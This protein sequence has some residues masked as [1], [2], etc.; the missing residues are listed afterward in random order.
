M[1]H[2]LHRSGNPCSLGQDFV[3]FAIA[4]QGFNAEGSEPKFK[5]FA[6]IAL[7]YNPVNFGDMKQG[8][9]YLVNRDEILEGFKS[10]SIMH[11]VF[12]NKDTMIECLK[13]IS[14]ADIGL[15]IVV[16]GLIHDVTEA[17]CQAGIKPH[18]VEHSLGVHGTTEKL[19]SQAVLDIS[20]MCGHGM[21]AFS[22]IEHL[23][24]EVKSGRVTLTEAADE[25]AKQCVCGVFNPVRAARIIE[26][27]L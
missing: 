10:N 8:N 16:S 14:K 26:Q 15:S 12:T 27:L 24:D 13:E 1:T 25:L 9:K 21:V 4:A 18:T 3:I 5:R 2:T 7:K 23:V 11:A 20:T 19:P 17:C 6:E 22:L